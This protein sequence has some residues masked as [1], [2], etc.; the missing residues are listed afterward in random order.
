V[1][2][3]CISSLLKSTEFFEYYKQPCGH[4]EHASNTGGRNRLLPGMQ[5]LSGPSQMFKGVCTVIYRLRI[6]CHNREA[7]LRLCAG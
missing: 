1:A 3:L 2:K 7:C 6:K 4:T 5:D